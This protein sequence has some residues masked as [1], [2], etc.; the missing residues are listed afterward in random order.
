MECFYLLALAVWAL[1]Q[2]IAGMRKDAKAGTC[3]HQE[4]I[5]RK[6]VHKVDEAQTGTTVLTC[7]R[8]SSFPA[9]CKEPCRQ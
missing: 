9:G 4:F 5:P 6:F 8:P 3:V 1:W 2:K 7:P